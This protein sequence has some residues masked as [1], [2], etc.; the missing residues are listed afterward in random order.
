[1]VL[2]YPLL[3]ILL[4]FWS[5]KWHWVLNLF[6][7]LF[8]AGVLGLMWGSM[9]LGPL[10]DKIDRKRLLIFSTF[11]YG[12]GSILCGTS[13]DFSL[14]VLFRFITG[15]GLGGAMPICISLC[16]EY[17]P[18]RYRMLLCTLSRSGFTVGIANWI[19]QHLSWYW[20]F[21]FDGILPRIQPMREQQVS[22]GLWRVDA[23]DQL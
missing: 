10:S 12:V 17:S 18:L 21:Y 13:S 1:M 11:V 4:Q 2:T 22:V 23:L 14:L 5:K 7:I 19:L 8:I 3:F 6:P 20:L 9:I 15:V 16:S